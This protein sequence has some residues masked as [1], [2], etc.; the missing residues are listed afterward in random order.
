MMSSS[1]PATSGFMSRKLCVHRPLTEDGRAHNLAGKVRFFSQ[2]PS[3]QLLEDP[4]P[5][6]GSLDLSCMMVANWGLRIERS[7]S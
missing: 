3:C 4:L 1:D 5:R 7:K 2:H 6:G